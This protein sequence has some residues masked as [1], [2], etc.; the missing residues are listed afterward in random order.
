MTERI[1][2]IYEASFGTYGAPRVHAELRAQGIYVGRKCVA[3]LMGQAGLQGVSRRRGTVTTRRSR[4]R[5]SPLDLV[6]RDFS[7]SAPARLWVVAPA[8]PRRAGTYVP[9]GSGFLY[10]AVARDAFSRRIVG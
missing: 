10:L 2:A 5:A 6:E 4:G 1:R 9:T 8:P 3:R 7:A